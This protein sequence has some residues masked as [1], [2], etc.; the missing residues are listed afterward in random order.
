MRGKNERSQFF[1]GL[2]SRFTKNNQRKPAHCGEER[3]K[4]GKAVCRL[5]STKELLEDEVV[6]WTTSLQHKELNKWSHDQDKNEADIQQTGSQ[7]AVTCQGNSY[8]LA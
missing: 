1:V 4:Q 3:I 7:K 5:E 8:S 6:N 2:R